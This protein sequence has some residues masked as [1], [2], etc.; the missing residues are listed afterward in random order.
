MT[1]DRTIYKF[2]KRT[3]LKFVKTQIIRLE[4]LVN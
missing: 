2:Y 4:N 1:M 3:R